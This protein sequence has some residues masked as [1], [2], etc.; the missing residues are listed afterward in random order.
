MLLLQCRAIRL[1][2]VIVLVLAARTARADTFTIVTKNLDG[3]TITVGQDATV[4]MRVFKLNASTAPIAQGQQTQLT[5][6]RGGE[7][8]VGATRARNMAGDLQF[9]FDLMPNN[10]VLTANGDPNK[11][12]LIVFSRNGVD[13]A[14]VPFLVVSNQTHSFSVAVPLATDLMQDYPYHHEPVNDCCQPVVVCPKH[15]WIFSRRR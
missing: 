1:A 10:P 4:N 9:T 7:I 15:G 12:I 11:V 6:A 3:T 2:S 14:A 13:T 5:M 8:A